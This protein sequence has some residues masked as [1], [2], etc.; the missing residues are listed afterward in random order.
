MIDTGIGRIIG[1]PSTLENGGWDNM[2]GIRLFVNLKPYKQWTI[3]NGYS[4][5]G[6]KSP[7]EIVLRLRPGSYGVLNFA[8]TYHPAWRYGFDDDPSTYPVHISETGFISIPDIP[9]ATN[10]IR[11]FYD[12]YYEKLGLILTSASFMIALIAIWG[13]D[14]DERKKRAKPVTRE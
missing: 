14:K 9:H 1:H 7:E 13:R 6:R 5:V 4:E 2:S 10:E 12:P 11:L 8:E 3:T